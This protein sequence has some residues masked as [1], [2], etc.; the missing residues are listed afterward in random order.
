M[1]RLSNVLPYSIYTTAQVRELDRIAIEDEGIPGLTL[2]QRAGEAAFKLLVRTW[3]RAEKIAVVCG[4]GNNAG[5]AYVLAR[6]AKEAGLQ[7]QVLQM[8]NVE[9]LKGDAR[10]CYDEMIATGLTTDSTDACNIDEFEVIVDGLLGSGLDREA[11][12]EWKTVI[13]SINDSSTNVLA[14][15]IPSGLNADN[16]QHMGVAVS[17]CK[18][19]TFI[20]TKRGL[21]TGEAADYCGEIYF[22][23]LDIPGRI[24]DA[25]GRSDCVRIDLENTRSF[26][27][28]RK[29]SSHKGD[30]GHLLSIGGDHGYLGAV[31]MASEAAARVGAGLVSVATRSVHAPLMNIGRPELMC[32]GVE[33][34]NELKGLIDK[35]SVI[36]IGPGLGQ[37]SWSVE[38]FAA[39]LESSLPQVMDADALNL[40]AKEPHY[41]DH[42]I[43]TP[44]PGE[45]ARLLNCSTAQI[46]EDRFS[47]AK[48]LQKQYGGVI[49]LK[50]N[51]TLVANQKGELH[52]C[53]HGN[54]GMASAGMG[55][56]LT[57]VIAGLLAQGLELQQAAMLGACLH[58]AAA[59]LASKSGQ[60]GLLASD[61]MPFIRQLV[62]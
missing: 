61:L 44:H 53:S 38:L 20:G 3:P 7:V 51:G 52:I 11:S 55:D 9:K 2:M 27:S 57:G 22:S 59:D 8:G 13:E 32:H 50:G 29:R 41:C 28:P 35:V 40:L 37:S 60:R 43:L 24:Y 58:G 1:S 25:L 4:L 10:I 5:D 34:R 45:A 19:I 48:A 18:T 33:G 26:L 14:L 62:D 31:R 15:D 36:A 54:P 17:A 47:A 39:V 42:R 12:G 56:V 49:V 30:F 6:L 23:D 16:G 46:Q 21:L